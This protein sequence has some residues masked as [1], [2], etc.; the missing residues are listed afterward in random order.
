MSCSSND[1]QEEEEEAVH[2]S[3]PPT[4]SLIQRIPENSSFDFKKGYLS[5]HMFNSIDFTDKPGSYLA[6]MRIR[7]ITH[8]LLKEKKYIVSNYGIS[9]MVN[10]IECFNDSFRIKVCN[11]ALDKSNRIELVNADVPRIVTNAMEQS[12]DFTS[13]QLVGC[14]LL[15]HIYRTT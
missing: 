1:E 6:C 4:T 10:L 15:K 3:I 11:L 13:L 8:F 7:L 2:L 14:G 9:L 12:N 5:D